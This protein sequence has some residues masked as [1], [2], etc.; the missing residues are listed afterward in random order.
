LLSYKWLII[1]FNRNIRGVTIQ[2]RPTQH[3]R[4]HHGSIKETNLQRRLAM[5]EKRINRR[6]VIKKAAYMTPIILTFLAMPAFASGGSGRDDRS[7]AAGSDEI[8]GGN[9]KRGRR[10]LWNKTKMKTVNGGGETTHPNK[11][12]GGDS[13]NPGGHGNEGGYNNPGN[14]KK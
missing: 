2:F 12:G 11:S 4:Q 8:F 14:S 6:D 1:G 5:S 10:W 7:E 9:G 13:T 3:R